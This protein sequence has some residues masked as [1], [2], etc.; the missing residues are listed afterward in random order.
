MLHHCQEQAFRP[1]PQKVDFIVGWASCPPKKALSCPPEKGL[2]RM[3]Q[4]V[5]WVKDL[6]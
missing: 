3:V 2:S 5:I 6:G 1:V 4:D